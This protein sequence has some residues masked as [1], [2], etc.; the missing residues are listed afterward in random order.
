MVPEGAAALSA[1]TD[2]YPDGDS[3]GVTVTWQPTPLM[4]GI[5][6]VQLTGIFDLI[7]AGAGDGEFFAPRRHSTSWI[8]KPITEVTGKTPKQYAAIITQ[9][10]E[11]GVLTVENYHNTKSRKKAKRAILNE[12]K[13]A[14]TTGQGWHAPSA[15]ER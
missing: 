2:E 12:A 6:A 9:W 5:D 1:C 4:N 11:N 13:A 10:I 8:G 3:I 15:D 14:A 7:R